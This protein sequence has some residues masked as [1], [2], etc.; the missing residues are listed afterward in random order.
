[1]AITLKITTAAKHW[2]FSLLAWLPLLCLVLW[3]GSS[4]HVQESEF[5]ILVAIEQAER[6]PQ[7][8]PLAA[9]Q[10]SDNAEDTTIEDSA[11]WPAS[12]LAKAPIDGFYQKLDIGFLPKFNAE[13]MPAWKAY[14]RP[15]KQQKNMV[16]VL[17]WGLGLDP[18]I[19][20]KAINHLPPEI[21]LVFSP[22]AERLQEWIDKAR[23]VGHEVYIWL[24]LQPGNY[25]AT[26]PGPNAL[27]LDIT[28]KQMQQRLLWILTRAAG[29]TGLVNGWNMGK[30]YS[31]QRLYAIM[32]ALKPHGLLFIDANPPQ[33][34]TLYQAGK[35]VGL[36]MML[37]D[38]QLL[39]DQGLT[40]I[41]RGI[42]Q[43]EQETTA[44]H[45]VLTTWSSEPAMLKRLQQWVKN[46]PNLVFAPPSALY[47]P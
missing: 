44:G 46:A 37:V 21:G 38:F 10:G 12:P 19:T 42:S 13:G 4:P 14:A 31:N 11:T 20:D 6:K 22:Y 28:E 27:M 40:V 41:E 25:P 16:G 7:E 33:D 8:N 36:S 34:N 5:P 1:M 23:A 30:N 47:H 17:V 18:V 24:P 32:N 26:D 43:I 39:G 9:S 35:D 29:Y 3:L 2:I 15:F 45:A